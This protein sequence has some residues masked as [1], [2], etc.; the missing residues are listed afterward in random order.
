MDPETLRAEIPAL[1][2]TVY[3]NTGATGP[4]PRRV[5]EATERTLE[6]VEYEAPATGV[7]PAAVDVFDEAREAVA[8]HIGA[9]PETVATTQSTTRGM[10]QLVAAMDWEPGDVVVRTDL[11]H[12]AGVFPADRLRREDGVEIRVV[13]TEGGRVDREAYAEAVEGAKLVV[14][15]SLTWTHGT[16]LS[17]SELVDVAHDAGA[18]VLV[19]AV[20]SVGQHPVDVEAWGADAVAGAGHK[21]LLGHWG[22]GFLFVA[23]DFVQELTPP[24]VGYRSVA[25]SGASSYD[26]HPDA[27]RFEVGTTAIG[28]FAGLVEAVDVVEQLGYDTVADRVE[29]LTDRLKAGIDDE[30]L[31]SPRDYESGLVSFTVDDPEATV[32]RLA[33]AGIRIR[34]LPLSGTVR[35]SVHAFN[36][37]GDVD[38]LLDAL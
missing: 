32:S 35:A 31:R 2:E 21:W 18:R 9:D 27:R 1:S 29:Q 38:A 19:D 5:I 14:F 33:D 7:Y 10:G 34:S 20:Q 3:L 6:H 8:G 4:S 24:V 12:A 22:A 15:S 25:D 11:E 36:T 13:E 28:P 17:V 16:R 37:A 26:L 23:P 30:R